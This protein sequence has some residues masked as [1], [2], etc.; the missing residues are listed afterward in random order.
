M[1]SAAAAPTPVAIM[2]HVTPFAEIGVRSSS[3]VR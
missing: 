2:S 1:S 3:R